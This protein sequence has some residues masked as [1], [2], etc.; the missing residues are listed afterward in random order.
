MLKRDLDR[1][2]K[3]KDFKSES[4]KFSQ[5]CQEVS[6]KTINRKTFVRSKSLDM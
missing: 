4:G 6:R 1:K 5:I 3:I 2:R